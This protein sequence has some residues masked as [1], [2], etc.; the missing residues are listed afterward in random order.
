MR[1][2]S[3]KG[4]RIRFWLIVVVAAWFT[5]VGFVGCTESSSGESEEP[6]VGGAETWVEIREPAHASSVL[7][8]SH[9]E[10]AVEAG[11]TEPLEKVELLVVANLTD[12]PIQI[13]QGVY[14]PEETENHAQVA[15]EMDVPFNHNFRYL[16]LIAVAETATGRDCAFNKI[17][18][19]DYPSQ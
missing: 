11:S 19:E 4:G 16:R 5:A 7:Y 3:D 18:L 10:I 12:I 1:L 17:M 8:G 14:L 2:N 15:F 9:L 6:V 13:N